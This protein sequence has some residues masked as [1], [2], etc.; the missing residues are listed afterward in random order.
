LIMELAK[1]GQTTDIV[2]RQTLICRALW[3][4]IKSHVYRVHLP[5]AD[6][7]IEFSDVSNRRNPSLFVDLVIGLACIHHRQRITE[8]CLNGETILYANYE[9]YLEAATLFNSQGDYLGTRL[10]K[11]EFEAVQYIKNQ[12]N[13]GAS[14]NGIFY[15]LDEKFPNDG[16]NA[17]KVRRLMDGRQDREIKG[18]AD[19]VP[20]IEVRWNITD[21]GSKTKVYAIP[22][23]LS[24]GIQVT[25]HDL[26]N[27]NG[28]DLSHLSHRFPTLGKEENDSS[29][30]PIP[31]SYPNYPIKEKGGDNTSSVDGGESKVE[32]VLSSGGLGFGKTGKTRSENEPLDSEKAPVP[33]G[34]STGKHGKTGIGLHPRKEDPDREKFKVGLAAHQARRDKHT[35]S[36]C[37]KHDDIPYIMHDYNGYYCEPCRRGDGPPSEPIKADPQTILA[38]AN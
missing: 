10:D 32:N 37:G 9:D 6:K 16:W 12:G 2:T 20:G 7:L 24:L 5:A 13:E 26:K 36:R 27:V 23:D 34:E 30:P 31:T 29:I 22:G 17:Q 38:S 18:L 4:D 19:T 15:H 21:S 14:I 11:S 33:Y 8:E 35:C 28:E 1:N 3:R 25:I